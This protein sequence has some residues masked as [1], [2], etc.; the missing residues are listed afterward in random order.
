MG[1]QG[2]LWRLQV[3]Y[4]VTN[5]ILGPRLFKFHLIDLFAVEHYKLDFS[6]YPQTPYNR[7][8]LYDC[9][10]RFVETI[11]DVEI[12]LDSLFNWVCYCNIKSIS[13]K[14]PLRKVSFGEIFLGITIDSNFIFETIIHE[15]CRKSNLEFHALICAKKRLIFKAFT[16]SQFNYCPLV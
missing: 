15:L 9:R 16:I 11:S 7:E 12:T 13:I 6:N 14:S 8:W 5:S 2:Y 1:S 4:G 10:S 3:I